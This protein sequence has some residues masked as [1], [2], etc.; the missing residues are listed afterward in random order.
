M[1]GVE[2]DGQH[3]WLT[4]PQDSSG[5]LTEAKA[6]G[7]A[8]V[9]NGRIRFGVESAPQIIDFADR[10][11]ID[12]TA[13]ARKRAVKAA[14]ESDVTISRGVIHV[15]HDKAKR[16]PNLVEAVPIAMHRD[17][18]KSHNYWSAPMS[19]SAKI[20]AWADQHGLTVSN[21]VREDA[22]TR[23]AQELAAFNLSSATST[24]DHPTITGLTAT[25]EPIQYPPIVALR[26]SRRLL[27]ADVPGLGK[28]LES[29]ASM[30]V[31]GEEAQRL[32]V[33]C[34]SNLTATLAEE[35]AEHF[36]PG[37]FSPLVAVGRDAQTIPDGVDAVIVGWA[38][39]DAWAEELTAWKP[40]ALI[41]DEGHF[42][43]AGKQ[44]IR[45]KKK[46]SRN[47]AGKVVYNRETEAVGGSIRATAS[48]D[49]SAVVRRSGGMIMVLTGTPITNRPIELLA[50]LEIL[51]IEEVF[52]GSVSFKMRYCGP[53]EVKIP[54]KGGGHRTTTEFKGATNLRELNTRLRS[55]GFYMRR[56]K[57]EWVESGR[58]QMK[59]VDGAAFYEPQAPRRPVILRPPEHAMAE[60]HMA[61]TRLAD[62]FADFAQ[63]IAR[64]SRVSMGSKV[65]KDKIA[66]KGAQDLTRIAELRVLAA[67]IKMPVIMAKVDALV[68]EGEK[69]VIAAHHK[70]IVEAYAERYGGL[71]IQGGMPLAKVEEAKRIFNTTPVEESPVIVLSMEACKAGHTLC[72]QERHGVGKAAR[73]MIFAEQ[74]WVPGDVEQVQD[75]IWRFGQPREVFI[76]NVLVHGTVDMDIYQI[77]EG[78]RASIDT[79]IDAAGGASANKE[80]RSGAGQLAVKLAA[81][82]LQG[83]KH[84]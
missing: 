23:W 60:Y 47:A 75:R 80:E 26:R 68:A 6:L 10:N 33:V 84:A 32:V 65:M 28:S 38:V 54:L 82:A 14:S 25:L 29:L 67:R 27:L 77:R 64:T 2:L 44:Q 61:E 40:D 12:V 71:K 46:P 1:P 34:P 55:S 13:A 20:V 51:G 76:H 70:E 79:A 74:G 59:Y 4:L 78:K 39:L 56:T 18:K 22:R 57:R 81:T 49:L 31:E 3:V 8:H 45:T 53:A 7:Y 83:R 37:T 48:T 50:L 15:R 72:L 41:I 17:S 73:T 9:R 52:G 36:Q 43:K 11:G 63:E 62:D 69:V 66:A 35:M 21:A 5:L 19:E 24:D 42:A 16:L 30:R 58:L